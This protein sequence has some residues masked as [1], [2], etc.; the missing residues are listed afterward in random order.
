VSY[1]KGWKN[2]IIKL[3]FLL[4]IWTQFS[5]EAYND[6]KH[7]TTQSNDLVTSPCQL[8]NLISKHSVVVSWSKYGYKTHDWEWA[9]KTCIILAQTW[10]AHSLLCKVWV[11]H[12][13]HPK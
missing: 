11:L 12:R 7:P 3:I 10:F 2:P 5:Y 6:T 1:E 9:Y 13:C 4:R 8:W